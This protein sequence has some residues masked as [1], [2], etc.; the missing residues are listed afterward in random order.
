MFPSNRA[1]ADF[2]RGSSPRRRANQPDQN[3]DV[4]N[5][6][7]LMVS[8]HLEFHPTALLNLTSHET[9]WEIEKFSQK[10]LFILFEGCTDTRSRSSGVSHTYLLPSS[11]IGGSG[12]LSLSFDPANVDI[13]AIRVTNP[14]KQSAGVALCKTSRFPGLRRFGACENGINHTGKVLF[15]DQRVERNERL[16]SE[17]PHLIS[18]GSHQSRSI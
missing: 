11:R 12:R 2:A 7:S 1:W 8:L 9:R 10:T 13:E 5:T 15:R 4:P 18:E 16:Y 6:R 14:E 3:A 17:R